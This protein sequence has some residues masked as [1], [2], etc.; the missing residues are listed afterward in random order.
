MLTVS[1]E[2]PMALADEDDDAPGGGDTDNAWGGDPERLRA[3]LLEG[4]ASSP[5]R[6]WDAAYFEELKN[7]IR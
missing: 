3:L 5:G 1:T 6:T 7:R 4:L 2:A